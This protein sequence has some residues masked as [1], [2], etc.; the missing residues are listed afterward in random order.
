MDLIGGHSYG[1]KAFWDSN[2]EW[3]KYVFASLVVP[4]TAGSRLAGK[5][6]YFAFTFWSAVEFCPQPGQ[7]SWYPVLLLDCLLCDLLAGRAC[8]SGQVSNYRL[9][10]GWWHC[11]LQSVIVWLCSKLQL[12]LETGAERGGRATV[13]KGLCVYLCSHRGIQVGRSERLSISFLLNMQTSSGAHAASYSKSVGVFS[14]HRAAKE[15][16]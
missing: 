11:V 2:P 8:R 13:W 6:L 1:W 9:V 16:S 15:W 12:C 5:E 10:V 4:S 3:S 14:Q 7:A